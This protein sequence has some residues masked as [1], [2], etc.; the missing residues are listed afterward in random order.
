MKINSAADLA[1]V[2]DP[3]HE[4]DGWWGCQVCNRI[5]SQFCS[6]CINGKLLLDYTGPDDLHTARKYAWRMEEWLEARGYGYERYCDGSDNHT[7]IWKP[8]LDLLNSDTNH[9][10]ALVAAIERVT[11]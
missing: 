10:A 11:G 9:T 4:V 1:A 3:S 2:L 5:N 7:A 8:V 6:K